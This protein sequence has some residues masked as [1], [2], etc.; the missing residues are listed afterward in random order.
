MN[1]ETKHS[2]NDRFINR[3]QAD[4]QWHVV[5]GAEWVNDI[6]VVLELN[7]RPVDWSLFGG[8]QVTTL[9]H[10]AHYQLVI[11]VVGATPAI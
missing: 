3:R 5:P 4:R 10:C 8:R 1:E 7:T 9:S 6:A 2:I 11:T